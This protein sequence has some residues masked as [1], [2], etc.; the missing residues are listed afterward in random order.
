MTQ[1]SAVID[2]PGSDLD[3]AKMP[4]HWLLARLGKRVLRPGGI[5]LT[6]KL[7]RGLSI[8][9][10]DDV[11]EFAPGLGV[12]ARLIL[13][14]HPRRYVGVERGAKAMRWTTR[15]LPQ[16]LNV[17]VV[18]GAADETKL[19][20]HSATVVLGEAMLTMNTQ[21]HKQRIAAEAFR[22]LRPGGRYG[23]H[24]LCV[25]PDDMTT[26]QKQEID[27]VLSSVIHVGARPL[28]TREWSALLEAAGFR[29]VQVG[30]APMHLL[31][32]RRL[33]QDEGV[34]GAL[35]LGK[36]ILVDGNAR[37]R[38]LAMR[39]AFE[40]YHENLSAIFVVAEKERA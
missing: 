3:V 36:N 18:V 28:P 32:P 31:R 6:Q 9:P 16:Q 29:I 23:I 34:L 2:L 15:Q 14:R 30:Y 33:M 37:R 21:E 8:G 40:R 20:A 13:E 19:P 35:R 26:Q 5:G 11:A 39:R 25:V 10:G 7:L 22:I 27:R 12:T 17:S 24:E 4:G 38:V 1:R